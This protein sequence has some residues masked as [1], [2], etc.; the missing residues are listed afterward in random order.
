MCS[1][2]VILSLYYRDNPEHFQMAINS[3][4]EQKYNGS[5]K[6]FIAVDGVV[7][8]KLHHLVSIYETQKDIYLYRFESSEGL[9][10]RLNFLIDKC[11]EHDDIKY[12]FRMDSDDISLPE[13]V[14]LQV[15]FLERNSDISVMGSAVIEINSVGDKMQNKKLPTSDA[16]LKSN[17]IK[18]CPFNHPTVVFRR[19]LLSRGIRYN[20][21][22]KNTQDYFLWIDLAANNFKFANIDEPLLLFRINNDFFSR[23]GMK[24]AINDFRAKLYAIEKLKMH[25]VRN[26]SFAILIFLLRISPAV[27]QKIVYRKFRSGVT[28]I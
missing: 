7:D 24:K 10:K 13:R 28:N 20:S 15:D 5:I 2:G 16:E 27:I 11:L 8:G 6:I 12:I 4:I 17:I 9:A 14:R 26:Y 3:L 25:S 23:R 22:L 19:D 21:K 18:R 1:V